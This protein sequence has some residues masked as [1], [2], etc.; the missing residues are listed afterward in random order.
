MREVVERTGIVGLAEPE[1]GL[2]TDSEV[3]AGAVYMD[4]LR[5]RF[6]TGQA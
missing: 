1:D 3:F 5:R 6:V 2:F 4:V